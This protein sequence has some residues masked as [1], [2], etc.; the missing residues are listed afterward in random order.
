VGNQ[1][2]YQLLDQ[3]G[4]SDDIHL[5]NQK[6]QLGLVTLSFGTPIASMVAWTTQLLT[7]RGIFK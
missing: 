1:E 7:R 3:H 4:I 2:F 5:L 6:L